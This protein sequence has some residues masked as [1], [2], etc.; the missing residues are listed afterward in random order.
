MRNKRRRWST[1]ITT[2][3]MIVI[4]GIYIYQ[5]LEREADGQGAQSQATITP[6]QPRDFTDCRHPTQTGYSVRR[7]G[8]AFA[9]GH[10]ASREPVSRL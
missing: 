10:G 7:C 5:Y 9:D 1:L 4:I 2:L 6:T 3:V 8:P